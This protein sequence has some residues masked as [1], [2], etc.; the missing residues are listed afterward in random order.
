MLKN[1]TEL[2][3]VKFKSPFKTEH[4]EDAH[5]DFRHEIEFYTNKKHHSHKADKKFS[6]RHE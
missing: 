1:H 3:T 5:I 4:G 2:E 6:K